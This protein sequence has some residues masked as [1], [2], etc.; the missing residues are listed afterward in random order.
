[1]SEH[2][3]EILLQEKRRARFFAGSVIICLFTPF[4]LLLIFADDWSNFAGGIVFGILLA[5]VAAKTVKRLV[6]VRCPKCHSDRMSEEY[7]GGGGQVKHTCQNCG[8]LFD[9]GTL[10]P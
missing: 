10:R 6:R 9:N 2:F 3:P 4:L 7:Y 8:A 1:M 5:I